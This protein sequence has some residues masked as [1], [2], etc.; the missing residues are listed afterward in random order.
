[1]SKRLIYSKY[2]ERR[3][4]VEACIRTQ[5]EVAK[6][7]SEDGIYHT[8]NAKN[9]ANLLKKF[10]VHVAAT[11]SADVVE[12]KH[13]RWEKT[14]DDFYMGLTTFK[15][16]VCREEWVFEDMTDVDNLNYH[17]CPNCGAKMDGE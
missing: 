8:D 14:E 2:I 12:V 11:G 6:I 16:S 3:A 5:K 17:Y 1:M 15:C 7:M 4:A 9:I 13:G 10:E